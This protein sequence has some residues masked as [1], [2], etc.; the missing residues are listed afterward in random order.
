[1][2]N[3]IILC[4][5]ALWGYIVCYADTT[6]KLNANGDTVEAMSA[7]IDGTNS[8]V[9]VSLGNDSN[10]VAANVTVTIEVQ[11]KWNSYN[12]DKITYM[13]KTQVGPQQTVTLTIPIKATSGDD[14]YI[15]ANV[16]IVSVTGSKCNL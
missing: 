8:C 11:Y 1:M 16:T 6:C 13:G 15:P 7:T 5:V 3:R 4:I 12:G 10:D 2:M 9:N 14:R